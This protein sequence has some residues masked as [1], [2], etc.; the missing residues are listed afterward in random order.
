[1][2][3]KAM[4]SAETKPAE[5]AGRADR[6]LDKGSDLP[7]LGVRILSDF[8]RIVAAEARLLEIN[9]IEAAQALVGRIYIAALL[10][11]VGA[12]GVVAIIAS[13]G[14]LLHEWMPWWQALGIL[15]IALI[16]LAE[17]L[18]RALTHPD[19]PLVEISTPRDNGPGR[20]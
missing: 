2:V 12:V 9:I 5:D 4:K 20:S 19:V 18:R 14:L 16:L 7:E 3:E 13:I 11:V 6:E 17:I 8:G 1:M 10:I 15:G